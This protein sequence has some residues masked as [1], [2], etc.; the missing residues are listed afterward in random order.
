MGMGF[1][2]IFIG[3]IAGLCLWT[4]AASAQDGPTG[5]IHTKGRALVDQTGE[6]FHVRGIGLGNWLMPEGYMFK[7]KTAKSP[8]AISALIETL[9]GREDAA[10]SGSFSATAMWPATIW[11]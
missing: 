8:R 7:F 6:A 10:R 4:A 3:G 2:R 9:V 5:F 1:R 11:S